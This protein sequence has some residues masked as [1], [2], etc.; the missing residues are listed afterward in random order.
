MSESIENTNFVLNTFKF[1][2]KYP[3]EIKKINIKSLSSN[4]NLS[5]F[6]GKNIK[7]IKNLNQIIMVNK[8]DNKIKIIDDNFE[9]IQTL[10]ASKTDDL[11]IFGNNIFFMGDYLGVTGV[12]QNNNLVVYIYKLNT[13]NEFELHNKIAL[14]NLA[15][16]FYP[17]YVND[18]LM[19]VQYVENQLI[20]YTFKFI[21]LELHQDNIMKMKITTGI[22]ILSIT[23]N[24]IFIFNSG[25]LFIIDLENN[26]VIEKL[27]I[28][29][30]AIES[31]ETNNDYLTLISEKKYVRVYD[32][33]LNIRQKINVREV[34]FIKFDNSYLI[35]FSSKN[36]RLE[37]LALNHNGIFVEFANIT[38]IYDTLSRVQIIG[39]R[40]IIQQ[41]TDLKYFDLPKRIYDYERLVGYGFPAEIDDNFGKFILLNE[42]RI[43]TE[44]QEDSLLIG[45]TKS[46]SD[47]IVSKKSN[48][49]YQSDFLPT[50]DQELYKDFILIS[51]DLTNSSSENILSIENSNFIFVEHPNSKLYFK[52]LKGSNMTLI[53]ELKEKLISWPDD[54]IVMID[55]FNNKSLLQIKTKSNIEVLGYE[56]KK[57][58][59]KFEYSFTILSEFDD[60]LVSD[61]MLAT[62]QTFFPYVNDSKVCGLV[63]QEITD[64]DVNFN[65]SPIEI[66]LSSYNDTDF[67]EKNNLNQQFSKNYLIEHNDKTIKVTN[68]FT[69]KVEL[70]YKTKDIDGIIKVIY[71]EPILVIFSKPKNDIDTLIHLVNSEDSNLLPY[72]ISNNK[73]ENLT[74]IFDYD[75]NNLVFITNNDIENII[76]VINFDEST[77]VNNIK[78]I[79]H[80][81]TVTDLRIYGNY[82]AVM[83]INKEI[84][85]Y[86]IEE[87]KAIVSF[88][89]KNIIDFDLNFNTLV[90]LL[91]EENNSINIYEIKPDFEL[92]YRKELSEINKS[93]KVKLGPGKIILNNDI[94]Y[95]FSFNKFNGMVKIDTINSN[96][97]HYYRNILVIDN[98]KSFKYYKISP[99][100]NYIDNMTECRVK[101]NNI[102]LTNKLNDMIVDVNLFLGVNNKSKLKINDDEVIDFSKM[103][104]NKSIVK[105]AIK[106]HNNTAVNIDSLDMNVLFNGVIVGEFNDKLPC[107][108]PGTLISTPNGEVPIETIKENSIIYDQNK[109][110]IKVGSVH[111]WTTT[112]FT[113]GTIPYVIPKDSLQENYPSENLYV[114][115]FHKI[116]LPNGD[117]KI[118]CN[119][120]LPFIKQMKNSNGLL[121]HNEK[122]I[123]EIKYYNLVLP[124]N[125]NYIANGIIV[126][127]LDKSNHLI[128]SIR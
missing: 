124:N 57:D 4:E 41:N 42:G 5:K 31:I 94:T 15:G 11:R 117:F 24:H 93:T 75:G 16:D 90:V 22:I 113:V 91:N 76:Y 34:D 20:F 60:V 44:K 89:D 126:E 61:K 12:F 36:N 37:I 13:M 127:S 50:I 59:R 30:L 64:L 3:E 68:L 122:Q 121:K 19:I 17:K 73:D 107:F 67:I 74:G 25:N 125:S 120:N 87:G 55:L 110:E 103:V 63:N 100:V 35:L 51:D 118:V 43:S 40:L 108:L 53:L 49:D 21:N 82:I 33:F 26:S 78:K 123:S 104:G 106:I 38:E 86:D 81:H 128:T 80:K 18:K 56:T 39:N 65:L 84:V 99:Q 1:I 10:F 115:P 47:I 119:I 96:L 62:Y 92:V 85:I 109:E 27:E 83:G 95:L 114:S 46:V 45:Y 72:V 112:N 8:L 7:I 6:K 14:E 32:K 77:E 101:F 9:V 88:T 29:C 48:S 71:S 105:M 66:N 116:R 98:T 52:S 111:S 2:K 23:N 70:E 54:G 58:S 102:Q 28:N 79:N 97:V 69:K